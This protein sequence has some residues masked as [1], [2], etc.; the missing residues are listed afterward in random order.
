VQRI[1][2]TVVRVVRARRAIRAAG[3]GRGGGVGAGRADD[4]VVVRVVLRGRGERGGHVVVAARGAAGEG[5]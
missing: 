5:G 4:A 1:R 3:G 2:S